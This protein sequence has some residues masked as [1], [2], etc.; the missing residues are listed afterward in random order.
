MEVQALD[1][2]GCGRKSKRHNSESEARAEEIHNAQKCIA[3]KPL[4][5]K[6]CFPALTPIKRRNSMVSGINGNG[7]LFETSSDG[8]HDNSCHAIHSSY[9]YPPEIN[10]EEKVEKN[11]SPR[12]ESKLPDNE[13]VDSTTG[14]M[15]ELKNSSGGSRRESNDGSELEV[16]LQEL[17]IDEKTMEVS[18][19]VEPHQDNGDKEN[20]G[21]QGASC[22]L[23]KP[24]EPCLKDAKRSTVIPMSDHLIG[25]LSTSVIDTCHPRTS[26]QDLDGSVCMTPKR[27]G[28]PGDLMVTPLV[29]RSVKV[30]RFM[31]VSSS[32]E[33][34]CYSDDNSRRSF[35]LPPFTPAAQM[36]RPSNFK[37]TGRRV[38]NFD[39]LSLILS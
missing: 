19:L 16:S 36:R 37:V 34:S 28:G 39:F 9:H 11:D 27:A 26:S 20:N 35:S 31:G 1:L 25:Q 5:P 22:D 30:T 6:M 29:G 8:L 38:A 7:V 4:N 3:P 14:N 24:L 32:E 12:V 2:H 33:S 23:A 13:C 21:G 10:F 15:D 18:G 17:S